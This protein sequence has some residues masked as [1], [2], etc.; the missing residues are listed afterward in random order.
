VKLDG[1]DLGFDLFPRRAEGV[2]PVR[3]EGVHLTDVIRSIMEESGMQKTVSGSFWRPDQLNMAGEVGFMWE[4]VLSTALK[5]RLPCRMGEVELDGIT[6]SPDGLEIDPDVQDDPILSEYKV[7]WASS[8]R[9]PADNWKWMAQVKGYCKVLELTKVKMYILYLNGDWKGTG[10][11]YKGFLIEFTQL[12][13]D[14]NWSMITNH[15]RSK[16]WI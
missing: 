9:S 13:I 14:E 8:K 2:D 15:A 16:K 12:E 3:T 6:C 5:D 7:V 1:I 10:P 4:D 11:Q